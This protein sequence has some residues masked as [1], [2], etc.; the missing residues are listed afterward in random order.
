[1]LLTVHGDLLAGLERSPGKVLTC[2]AG[3]LLLLLAPE[4]LELHNRCTNH[5]S[6]C[7]ALEGIPV[8]ERQRSG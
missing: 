8:A 4:L 2:K 7:A 3:L 1:M 6:A 5:H